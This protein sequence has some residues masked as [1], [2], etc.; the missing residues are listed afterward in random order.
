[1]TL[2]VPCLAPEYVIQVSDRRLA[3]LRSGRPVNDNRNK[4]VQL[5]RNLVFGYTGLAELDGQPTDE[6]LQAVLDRALRKHGD[7]FK[8]I[9]VVRGEA[10][11]AFSRI[12][13]PANMK[14]HAFCAVGWGCFPGETTV[15]PFM[16]V[17][18]NFAQDDRLLDEALPAFD[19]RR[20]RP[21]RSALAVFPLG[22]TLGER[23]LEELCRNLLRVLKRAGGAA[24]AARMITESMRALASQNPLVGKSLLINVLPKPQSASLGG[25]QITAAMPPPDARVL[26]DY[27]A[28]AIS[29]TDPSFLY[30]PA[31]MDDRPIAWGPALVGGAVQVK[32]IEL[33]VATNS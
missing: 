20:V 18:S 4:A 2:I 26:S 12:R 28:G 7:R 24:A 25:P 22:Q 19:L 1:M 14:R 13:L 21:G 32:G 5:G 27:F 3:D 29:S 17:V 6:W 9:E 23:P 33:G 8:A 10:T 11:A 30:L 16:Y 15:E 31:E